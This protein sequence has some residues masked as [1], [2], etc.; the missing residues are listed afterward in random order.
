MILQLDHNLSRFQGA[1]LDGEGF[2]SVP[3]RDVVFY[4][5]LELFLAESLPSDSFDFVVCESSGEYAG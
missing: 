2:E 3:H 1:E 4:R 5:S